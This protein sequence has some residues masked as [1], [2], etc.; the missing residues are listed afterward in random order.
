M[1]PTV[2]VAAGQ[3][4]R[5]DVHLVTIRLARLVAPVALCQASDHKDGTS[6]EASPQETAE[7]VPPNLGGIATATAYAVATTSAI[8]GR[9]EKVRVGQH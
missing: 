3:E 8:T 5:S 1:D 9:R 7:L 6:T 2:G 4:T